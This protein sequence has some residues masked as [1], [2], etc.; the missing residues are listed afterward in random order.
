MGSPRARGRTG[1]LTVQF[2][3]TDSVNAQAQAATELARAAEVQRLSPA[4]LPSRAGREHGAAAVPAREVGGD[5]Y[6]L[7]IEGPRASA[8]PPR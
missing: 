6:D 7:R 4:E 2:D 8:G 5:F 1:G 3:I